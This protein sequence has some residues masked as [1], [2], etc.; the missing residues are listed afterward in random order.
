MKK[1]VKRLLYIALSLFLIACSTFIYKKFFAPSLRLITPPV[2]TINLD[3]VPEKRWESAIQEM[4]IDLIL[5]FDQTIVPVLNQIRPKIQPYLAKLMA[6]SL[7]PD[8]YKRELRG[9]VQSLHKRAGS[10]LKNIT[11]E[12]LFMLTLA[13]EGVIS[14]LAGV[15]VGNSGSPYLFR[16]L[17]WP[18]AL[19]RK[20]TV[21]INWYKHG[22]F[23]FTTAGF[24]FVL[25]VVTGQRHGAFALAVNARRTFDYSVEQNMQNYLNAPINVWSIGI[26]MRYALEYIRDYHDA[27]VLFKSAKLMAPVYITVAGIK[28]NEGIILARGKERVL[29]KDK[30]DNWL[31]Y[32]PRSGKPVNPSNNKSP[33]IVDPK[34]AQTRYII[35]SNCDNNYS[36]VNQ[37]DDKKKFL[38]EKACGQQSP[39]YR[40]NSALI[41]CCLLTSDFSVDDLFNG[42]LLRSPVRNKCIVYATVMCPQNAICKSYSVW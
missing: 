18:V 35:V 5:L 34:H 32:Y 2:F 14:C 38:N 42:V 39:E 4:G 11:Y 41:S 20:I 40:R 10:E 8:E 23:L 22:N 13:Y 36:L 21:T 7:L 33:I 30:I 28:T 12:N 3:L 15:V 37:I 26:L 1:V 24:P 29:L 6:S 17:D 19:L 25:S 31:Y 16:N 9:I 27:Y